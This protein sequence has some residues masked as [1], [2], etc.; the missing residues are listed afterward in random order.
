MPARIALPAGRHYAITWGISDTYGGMTGALLHRSRA[1]VRLGGVR[2]DVLTFDTRPDY[3]RVE[4]GLRSSGKIVPG[5]RLLNVWDWLREHPSPGD[6]AGVGVSI[7]GR[8]SV[9]GFTPLENTGAYVPGER[10]GRVMNRTRYDASGSEPL[11][12]DHYRA[13]GSLAV[14]DRRDVT[15]RG[16]PGGRSIVLCDPA[17][18]PVKAWNGAWSLYRWW[19]DEVRDRERATMIVDSKTSARFMVGYKRSNVVSA[20][21][22]HG[23]HLGADGRSIRASRAAVFENPGAFNLLVFLTE[24][25][26]ADALPLLGPRARTAVIPNGREVPR[27]SAAP[28]PRN[29]HSGIMLSAL[30]DRKR[31]DHAVRAIAAARAESTPVTLDIYGDGPKR[32]RIEAAIERTDGGVRLHGY[33]P[34]ARNHLRESSFLLLTSKS[35]GFPLVLVEAMAAGCLPIAYDIPYGPADIIRDGFNGFLVPP[36]DL[37]ALTAAIER[38]TSLPARKLDALRR[39]AVRT[40]AAYSDQA[41]TRRWAVE[42]DRAAAPNVRTRQPEPP[43]PLALRARRKLARLW[44]K[45]RETRRARGGL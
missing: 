33:D 28:P 40:S 31:V 17:G 26:R 13:D 32:G 6:Y 12:V 16:T 27:A 25:Q 35:E 38:V 20:H 3:P 43:D 45:R 42:L 22:L 5:M 19:L 11:Q 14:S 7:P 24:R 9:E 37:A 18:N 15:E 34:N 2:V 44:H 10:D 8:K 29:V 4:Q 41:V 21:V 39:N 36:G 23:S 30:D 1:F